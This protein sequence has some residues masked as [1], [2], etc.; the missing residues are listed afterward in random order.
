MSTSTALEGPSFPGDQE[1]IKYLERLSWS[2][3]EARNNRNYDY[4]RQADFLAPSWTASLDYNVKEP[5]RL[6][7]HI[8]EYQ[9]MVEAYPEHNLRLLDASTSLDLE[10]RFAAVYLNLELTGHPPGVIQTGIGVFEWRLVKQTWICSKMTGMR[11]T[12]MASD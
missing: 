9:K 5:P 1:T 7:D 4:I 11:G 8:A 6:E 3:M 10:H 2:I 12:G